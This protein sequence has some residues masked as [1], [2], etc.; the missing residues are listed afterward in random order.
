MIPTGSLEEAQ[1]LIVDD[2]RMNIVLLEELL[3][4]A[5]YRRVAS[6]TDSRTVLELFSQ[7]QPD[8]IL[9]DLMMPHLDGYAVLG[10]LR[11]L[12][13]PGSY[14]PILV[15]TS[16]ISN[17][18]KVRALRLG[19]R[20]FMTKPFNATEAMLRVRN[21]LETRLLHLQLQEQKRLVEEQNQ[22]L[23]GRVRERTRALEE[24]HA[25]MLERLARAAEFRDDDTGQHTQRVA[26]LAAGLGRAAGLDAQTVDLIERAAPL[27][28]VGK[29]GISDA[30]LLKPGRL[31]S[32]ESVV[33]QTHTTIGAA[34][35]SGG[36]SP[37]MQLAEE[38]ALSH[39]ERWDGKG[40]PQGLAGDA[41]PLGGRIVTLVDVFDALTHA[42]PYK[43]AWPVADALA[44]MARGGGTQF[45]PHLLPL[46][47]ALHAALP[48]P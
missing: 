11:Q 48:P 23:E 42:R 30:I 13:P 1:L 31:T 17:E 10:Q 41:I 33:M 21:L 26:R 34:L 14:L 12:I 37:L 39:H 7:L 9:L 36:H 35:L 47:L 6:T 40:Y 38:I 27:H 25:E 29:I 32:E 2:E 45:D 5:G 4:R 8:L 19:A 15:L 20:D 43:P 18:S 46:F 3:Q 28:D 16:D 24:A 22:V 44:E